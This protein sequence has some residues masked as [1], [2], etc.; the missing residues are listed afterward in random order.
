MDWNQKAKALNALS[1]ISIKIGT[2]G[3]WYVSQGLEI[4]QG[5][6]LA[7]CVGRGGDPVEAID[8]HWKE[9]VLDLKPGE[10]LVVNA[11]GKD[12]KAVRWNGFM[13]E[14]VPEEKAA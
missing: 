1:P 4:K 13:W 14:G 11:G 7:S 10:Y 9:A 5:H 2:S 12:R 6:V 8:N 3:H